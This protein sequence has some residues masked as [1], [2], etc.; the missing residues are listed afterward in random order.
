MAILMTTSCILLPIKNSLKFWNHILKLWVYNF[1]LKIIF[2]NYD[3]F[4]LEIA[5]WKYSF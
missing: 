4:N 3:F 1:I 5:F 2:Y